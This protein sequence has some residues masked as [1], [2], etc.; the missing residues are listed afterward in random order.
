MQSVFFAKLAMLFDLHA[1][2]QLFLVLGALVR[3][4]LAHAALELD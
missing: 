4:M 2:W 3:N 1:R